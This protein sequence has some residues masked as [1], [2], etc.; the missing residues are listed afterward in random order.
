MRIDV[1]LASSQASK[2]SWTDERPGAGKC[3]GT[4]EAIPKER[5]GRLILDTY[6]TA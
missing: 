6:K 2:S 3:P 5:P 1:I 4:A